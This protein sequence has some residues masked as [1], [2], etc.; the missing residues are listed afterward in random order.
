M[1]KPTPEEL[2]HMVEMAEWLQRAVRTEFVTGLSITL[3]DESDGIPVPRHV[4]FALPGSVA[5]LAGGYVLAQ[6]DFAQR[7]AQPLADT[8]PAP[9]IEP[10]PEPADAPGPIEFE[11]IGPPADD[12]RR[13]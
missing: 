3:V 2:A 12:P 8:P 6:H 10:D 1:S 5:S 4:F 11:D 13:H 9:Q 7:M